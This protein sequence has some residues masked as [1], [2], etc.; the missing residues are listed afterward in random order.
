LGTKRTLEDYTNYSGVDFVKYLVHKDAEKGIEPP[1]SNSEEG[2]DNEQVTF[3]DKLSWD[4]EKIEKVDNVRFWAMIVL[5]Q[6][7]VAIHREDIV[8]TEN[9]DIIDGKITSRNFKFDR[10]KNRQIP[11]Q[12]LVWP[13]SNDLEWKTPSYFKI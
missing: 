2:W 3:N 4:F 1:C 9:K 13:F 5:D 8:Y 10:S 6:N 12:L 7:G 11:T